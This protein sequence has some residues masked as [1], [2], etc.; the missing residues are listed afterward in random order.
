MMPAGDVEQTIAHTTDVARANGLRV[1][2]SLFGNVD[3]AQ[4]EIASVQLRLAAARRA[5]HMPVCMKSNEFVATQFGRRRGGRRA[6]PSRADSPRRESR[7][8]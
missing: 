2:W 1:A 4:A 7:I 6:A 8:L 3:M 5:R